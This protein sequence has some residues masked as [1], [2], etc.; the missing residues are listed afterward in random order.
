MAQESD[1]GTGLGSTRLESAHNF[2]LACRACQPLSLTLRVC[3]ATTRK[4]R[5]CSDTRTFIII[6]TSDVHRSESSLKPRSVEGNM[7]CLHDPCTELGRLVSW[8]SSTSLLA[9]RPSPT[10]PK[11]A[12]ASR[13]TRPGHGSLVQGA[14]I[15]VG[16]YLG[17]YLTSVRSSGHA[18]ISLR[19][20]RA[21][22]CHS[23]TSDGD[24]TSVCRLAKR[25]QRQHVQHVAQPQRWATA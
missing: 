20:T 10:R 8:C 19:G 9:S 5:S 6:R 1:A 24:A 16:V 14:L 23:P 13:L 25:Y 4:E 15:T 2:T 3:P 7:I 18:S 12:R 11:G 22:Q 17:M 21:P